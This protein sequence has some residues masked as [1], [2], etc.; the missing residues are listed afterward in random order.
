MVNHKKNYKAWDIEIN[1]FKN[2]TSNEDKLKFLIRFAILAPSS[3]NS[4]P[5]LFTIEK[6]KILVSKNEKRTLPIG[7]SN[8]RQLYISLGCAIENIVVVGNYVGF[9][10]SVIFNNE[11]DYVSIFLKDKT[12]L[13]RADNLILNIK[14]RI[15]NRGQ[16]Y[17]KP[18]NQ[19]VIDLINSYKNIDIN[20]D[21]ITDVH[22]KDKL[23]DIIL[24]STATSMKDKLFRK[25]L[26]KYIIPNNSKLKI[27]MPGFTI[28]LPGIV[29]YIAPLLLNFFDVSKLSRKK[30]ELILKTTPY[31]VIIGSRN[32]DKESWINVGR[33]F[34]NI[35]LVATERDI[36]LAVWAAPIQ[37]GNYFKDIQE[38]LGN[39][40]RPQMLFRMGYPVENLI[41]HSP[42][43]EVEEV[44]FNNHSSR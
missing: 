26:S 44:I 34:Q 41:K 9:D 19:E 20:T 24:E 13:E 21:V 17:N 11:K 27:G 43:L 29:S 42:R 6:N 8:N 18:I 16:Y 14:K 5:W 37:I 3:H 33:I 4:Q 25:E 40:F 2:L 30:D 23:T 32:D 36:S 1:D 39:N 38:I 12:V 31:I 7:D 35:A 10:S 28:G 15:T 22:T